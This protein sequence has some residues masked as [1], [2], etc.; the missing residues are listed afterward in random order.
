MTNP[1]IMCPR[2]APILSGDALD[3]SFSENVPIASTNTS[4]SASSQCRAT[5]KGW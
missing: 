1:M 5:R 2:N 3:N 4:N